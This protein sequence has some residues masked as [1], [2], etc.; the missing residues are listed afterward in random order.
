MERPEALQKERE[1]LWQER[2]IN[3]NNKKKRLQLIDFLSGV[4]GRRPLPFIGPG[5][6]GSQ[7]V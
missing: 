2:K 3:D 7:E 4:T 1:E 6:S 5:L